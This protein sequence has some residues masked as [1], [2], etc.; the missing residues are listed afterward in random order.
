MTHVMSVDTGSS[1]VPATTGSSEVPNPNDTTTPD[2]GGNTMQQLYVE[3]GGSGGVAEQLEGDISPVTGISSEEE[4]G[5]GE[6]AADGQ[7]GGGPS[8]QKSGWSLR[9]I[10]L[11]TPLLHCSTESN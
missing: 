1:G 10:L 3:A 4:Q 5:E 9:S 11:P 6:R 7:G 8:G 2:Y